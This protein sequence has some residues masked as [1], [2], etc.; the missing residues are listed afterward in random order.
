MLSPLKNQLKGWQDINEVNTLK[1]HFQNELL[2]LIHESDFCRYIYEKPLGYAGDFKT[3]VMIW[4]A[5]RNPQKK[6]VSKT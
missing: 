5:R 2:P 1:S 6:Y 3:Q 4:E